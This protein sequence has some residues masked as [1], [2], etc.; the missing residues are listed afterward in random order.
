MHHVIT[1]NAGD[2]VE[3]RL[4]LPDGERPEEIALVR[5]AGPDD[6]E[7]FMMKEPVWDRLPSDGVGRSGAPIAPAFEFVSS[8][9]GTFLK[10]YP[11]SY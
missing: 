8:P 3:F 11:K 5:A 2:T 6:T 10:Y 7:G 9:I 4:E 1:L